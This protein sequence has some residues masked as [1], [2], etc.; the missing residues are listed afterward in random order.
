MIRL[1]L[2]MLLALP[3]AAQAA[4]TAAWK[5]PLETLAPDQARKEKI[6]KLEKPPGKSAFFAP[7]DELWDVSGIL[8]DKRLLP[9]GHAESEAELEEETNVDRGPWKGQWAVW[10]ARSG[11]LV[12]RGSFQDLLKAEAAWEFKAAPVK[13]AYCLDWMRSGG[14]EPFQSI[15]VVSESRERIEKEEGKISLHAEADYAESEKAIDINLHVSWKVDGE[16]E[17]WD[18]GT[19]LQLTGGKKT[20]VAKH[21]RGETAWELYLTCKLQEPDG[22]EPRLLEIKGGAI[23]NWFC[24]DFLVPLPPKVPL[25][26]G[27]SIVWHRIPPPFGEYRPGR[28]GAAADLEVPE[29]LRPWIASPLASAPVKTLRERG[30]DVDAPGFFVGIEP[31][32]WML[33][34]VADEKTQAAVAELVAAI[35][36]KDD[37]PLFAETKPEQGNSGL[38]VRDRL[39]A[40]LS[41]VGTEEEETIFTVEPKRMAEGIEVKLVLKL[42]DGNADDDY[43][44]TSAVLTPNQWQK[45]TDAKSPE[46]REISIRVGDAR[47]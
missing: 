8:R 25:A 28:P 39:K 37:P 17:G 1:L 7:G 44:E 24:D 43:L 42:G 4:Y 19:S 33:V 47:P 9:F 3:M 29:P 45:V 31:I 36:V 20:L 23:E 6:H 40:V 2:L 16:A 26:E 18:L 27:R 11:R 10:N 46:L 13:I 15:N 34:V 38:A 30:I 21:G 22:S 12:A 41:K 5:V 14:A 32:V 35:I